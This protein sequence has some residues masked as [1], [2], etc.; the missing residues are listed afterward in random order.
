MLS[1]PEIPT[2]PTPV[3]Q[4]LRVT[5]LARR[6]NR[7][8]SRASSRPLSSAEGAKTSADLSGNTGST[9][10]V[11]SQV[12]Y[13]IIAQRQ[14]LECRFRRLVSQEHGRRLRQYNGNAFNFIPRFGKWQQLLRLSVRGNGSENPGAGING[15]RPSCHA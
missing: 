9:E 12:E 14:A 5:R 6:C 13:P 11:K 4:A 8:I 15:F 1:T 7:R 2:G 10:T 3:S